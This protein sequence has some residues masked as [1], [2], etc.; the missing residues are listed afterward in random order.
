MNEIKEEFNFKINDKEIDVVKVDTN[1]LKG[2]MVL[3][4]PDGTKTEVFLHSGI[5]KTPH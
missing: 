4:H 3:T 5:V 1:S 2:C